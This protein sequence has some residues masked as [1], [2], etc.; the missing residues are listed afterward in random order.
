MNRKSVDEIRHDLAR[1]KEEGILPRILEAIPNICFIAT[2]ERQIVFANRAMLEVVDA[3]NR[4]AIAGLRPGEALGCIH[5]FESNEGCGTSEVCTT[6]GALDAII[7]SSLGSETS[8]ECRITRSNGQVMDLR[9]WAAPTTIREKHY[10]VVTLADTSDEKRR[11]VLERLFF[12]D[13]LNTASA[14]RGFCELLSKRSED[15]ADKIKDLIHQLSIRLLEEI[16]AQKDL[17]DAENGELAINLSKISTR[18]VVQQIID[19]HGQFDQPYGPFATISEDSEDITMVS[20]AVLLRRVLENLIKNALE[21]VKPG[22]EVAV[23]VYKKNGSVEFVIRNSGTMAREIQLQIFQRSFSTKGQGRG[24]GTYSVKLL[25]EKYL[26]GKV[27]FE[28]D[29]NNTVFRVLLP[30]DCPQDVYKV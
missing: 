30:M 10:I 28:S 20:D 17:T 6:C 12:H 8:A 14:I 13:V 11:R 15:E 29:R 18:N 19:Q 2:A 25:T 23:G 5:A 1:I 26:K 9:V 7:D 22:D 3:A 27:S 21:A 16:S 24:I 4:L